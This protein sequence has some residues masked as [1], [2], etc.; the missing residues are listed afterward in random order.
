MP[1]PETVASDPF[2]IQ[3]SW[4]YP[5]NSDGAFS[6]FWLAMAAPL[7]ERD[8]FQE[9]GALWLRESGAPDR[10]SIAAWI[11][12]ETWDGETGSFPA[13][14]RANSKKLRWD[15]SAKHWVL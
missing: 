12:K 10:E 15:N 6:A 11:A 2:R 4:Q 14:L 3:D 8:L 1:T 7:G 5:S 9:Q 13:W